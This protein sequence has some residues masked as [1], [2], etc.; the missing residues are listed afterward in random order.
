MVVTL[1]VKFILTM[2]G[3]AVAGAALVGV[4]T[5]RVTKVELNKQ[6]DLSLQNAV[7][8]LRARP[9]RLDD[10]RLRP[11]P[12]VRTLRD[13]RA[14]GDVVVQFLGPGGRTITTGSLGLPV[15]Q[16]DLAVARAQGSE[17]VLRTVSIAGQDYRLLTASVGRGRGAVQTARSLTEVEDVLQRLSQRILVVATLLVALAAG[18]GWLLA[19]QLTRRLT[20]LTG[21]AE[22]V[23]KTAD[24]AVRVPVG[25]RDEAG[26]LA[27]AFNAMLGAL[28]QAREEQ[29]RLV[30]NAAHELRTPL[31]SLRTNIYAL[32]HAEVSD[33][34]QRQRILSDLT[35]ETEELTALMNEVVELAGLGGPSSVAGTAVDHG[36]AVDLGALVTRV[37]QRAASRTGRSIDLRVD[38]SLVGGNSAQLGRAVSNLIENALKFDQGDAPLEV[39]CNNGTVSVA[40]RGPGIPEADLPRI[41][42]RFYRSA[43]ARAQNGSG[44]GLAIVAEIVSAHHGRVFAH[45]R[46]GGGAEVGFTLPT[47]QPSAGGPPEP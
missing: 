21:A 16:T 3:L 12:V 15:E 18:L 43:E 13:F 32:R 28:S 44:L 17:E 41:F 30:E 5:F 42:E 47:V 31:T 4:A 27:A 45:N 6:V 33:P 2:V 23:A 25:G 14:V 8:Q 20:Q 22:Q 9:L 24:P 35:S 38:G 10:E 7:G 29:Q 1:R 26:R 11:A 34:E 46:P 19:S 36:T 37:A 39:R 40:D